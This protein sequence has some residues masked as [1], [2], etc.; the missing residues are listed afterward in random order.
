MFNEKRDCGGKN[1]KA[2]KDIWWTLE[3]GHR[4]WRSIAVVKDG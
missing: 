3:T 1:G 2:E 4:P